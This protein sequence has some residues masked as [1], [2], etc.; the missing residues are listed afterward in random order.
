MSCSKKIDKVERLELLEPLERHKRVGRERKVEE[1]GWLES[2]WSRW[3]GWTG[4]EG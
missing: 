4:G 3:R 2:C 1:P